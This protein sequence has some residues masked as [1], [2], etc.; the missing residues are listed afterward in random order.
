M[1]GKN[2]SFADFYQLQISND[3]TFN[4]VLLDLKYDANYLESTS[5]TLSSQLKQNTSY[6]WRMKSISETDF[7]NSDWSEMFSF[8]TGIRTSTED[9]FI[10]EEYTLSQNYPNP[11]NPSTQIHYALP[12]ATQVTLEVFNSVGQKVIRAGEWAEV[13]RITYRHF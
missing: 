11:F 1:S 9:E 4:A 10:P 12:E 5:F 2:V 13:S 6:Y 3:S 8:T 7:F